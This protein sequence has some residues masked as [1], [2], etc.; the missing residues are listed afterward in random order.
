MTDSRAH[1]AGYYGA[2]IAAWIIGGPLLLIAVVML[3]GGSF[4]AAVLF[5][6][7]GL[8]MLGIGDFVGGVFD[9]IK[10]RRTA[11]SANARHGRP[12]PSAR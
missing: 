10:D 11:F 8:I 7:F 12:S 6:V 3:F 4:I 2:Q 5:A 1:S 9:R